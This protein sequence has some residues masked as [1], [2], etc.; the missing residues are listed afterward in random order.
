MTLGVPW[1]GIFGHH[2]IDV[3]FLGEKHDFGEDDPM[4]HVCIA[5]IILA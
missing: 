2:F 5:N 1:N 3:F 4:L